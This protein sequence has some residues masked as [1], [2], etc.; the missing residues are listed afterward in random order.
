M[1]FVRL[2]DQRKRDLDNIATKAVLDLLTAH[3]VI[4]YDANV[5]KVTASW[6]ATTPPGMVRVTIEPV[7][8]MAYAK[9]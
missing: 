3:G 4:E 6:N 7:M 1:S 2:A 8:V 9:A 5:V